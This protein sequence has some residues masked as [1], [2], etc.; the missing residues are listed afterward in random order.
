MTPTKA[1]LAAATKVACK[2]CFR[3]VAKSQLIRHEI[4]CYANPI[5]YKECVVCGTQLVKQDHKKSVT[6]SHACSNKYKPRGNVNLVESRDSIKNYRSRCFKAH[7]KACIICGES[8]I[9]EVHHLDEDKH[10]VKPE[11]L[12]PLCPTHH[13][14]WHS[15]HR[16]LIYNKVMHYVEEFLKTNK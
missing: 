5:N 4:N 2:H 16:T 10:N 12:L 13:Q 3:S 15:K 7:K 11:N 6:C 1:I 8:N 14:Y 9:V